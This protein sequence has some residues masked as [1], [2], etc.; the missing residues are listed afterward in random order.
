MRGRNL[1]L[2]STGLLW[3]VGCGEAATGTA[4]YPAG[5]RYYAQI[6]TP[7]VDYW[8]SG[9]AYPHQLTV[10]VVAGT[11]ATTPTAGVPGI[12]VRFSLAAGQGRFADT[13]VVT[14]ANGFATAGDWVLG[15]PGTNT[16]RV[17]I[18]SGSNADSLQLRFVTK[19]FSALA[20]TIVEYQ[21]RAE[22]TGTPEPLPDGT[23]TAGRIWLADDGTFVVETQFSQVPLGW[24]QAAAYALGTYA[25]SDSTIQFVP[26]AG[27]GWPA[28]NGKLVRD[29]L[30]ATRDDY[31]DYGVTVVNQVF[32][33]SGR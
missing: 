15:A 12:P 16:V 7:T 26:S 18:P 3:V 10:R 20:K 9:V 28:P 14:D 21:L 5:Y 2:V 8:W 27:N 6:A 13:V 32:V 17:A 11:S 30:F 24:T 29:T 33:K 25:R 4:G 31:E 1:V 23:V 22:G 19:V